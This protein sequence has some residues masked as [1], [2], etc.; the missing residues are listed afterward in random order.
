M[1]SLCALSALCLISSAAC[2][3]CWQ[4][5][6]ETSKLSFTATQAGAPLEGTFHHYDARLCLDA[7]SGSLKVSVQTASVDTQL[8][9]LDEAL[10]GADF[11]DVTHWP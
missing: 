9:E 11:F 4:P 3:D 5:V 2:A 6:P 10:R 8:P 7:G 1:R